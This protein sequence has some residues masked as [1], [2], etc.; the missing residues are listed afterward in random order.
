L[1]NKQIADRMGL[2]EV[3]VKIHR[4]QAMRKM[5]ARSVPDLVRKI[6]RVAAQNHGL[7]KPL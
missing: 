7:S 6:Q 4:S 5:E 2:S 3:T 1:M